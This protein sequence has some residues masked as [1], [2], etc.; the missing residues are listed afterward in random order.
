[1]NEDQAID[2]FRR[3]SGYDA[4]LLVSWVDDDADFRVEIGAG[5]SGYTQGDIVALLEVAK[6]SGRELIFE[7]RTGAVI[8]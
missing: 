6:Q 4:Q 5:V 1:M 8:V 7:V 3:V 2:V